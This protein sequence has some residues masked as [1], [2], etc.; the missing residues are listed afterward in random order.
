MALLSFAHPLGQERV[1]CSLYCSLVHKSLCCSLL[2]SSGPHLLR[3]VLKSMM[4]CKPEG[5]QL[6]KF[7]FLMSPKL[8]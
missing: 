3:A 2:D 5:S 1:G 4:L 8:I 6:G 7:C